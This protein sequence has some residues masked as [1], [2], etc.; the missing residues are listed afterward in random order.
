MSSDGN[1]ESVKVMCDLL[2]IH[3][4]LWMNGLDYIEYEFGLHFICVSF[5]IKIKWI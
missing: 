5:E 4:K 2:V 1:Y 3:V